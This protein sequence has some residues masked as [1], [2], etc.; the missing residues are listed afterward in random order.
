VA[1]PAQPACLDLSSSFFLKKCCLISFFK[2]K[3]TADNMSSSFFRIQRPGV[4][5][6]SKVR[7]LSIKN[8]FFNQCFLLKTLVKHL[9]KPI[10][11]HKNL[12]KA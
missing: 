2:K 11:H 10:H 3:K 4:T 1:L 8:L 12:K 9:D 6:K 5:E 7:F